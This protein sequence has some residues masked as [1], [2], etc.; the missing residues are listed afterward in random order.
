MRY[1]WDFRRMRRYHFW[2]GRRWITTKDIAWII[3]RDANSPQSL[4]SPTS[5][6]SIIFDN[7]PML[8]SSN[9]RTIIW[10]GL[11]QC[12]K[13]TKTSYFVVQGNESN[14]S[15]VSTFL[16]GIIWRKQILL[17][18]ATRILKCVVWYDLKCDLRFGQLGFPI[19]V[20]DKYFSST[21]R[22]LHPVKRYILPNFRL[23][24]SPRRYVSLVA[25]RLAVPR[26]R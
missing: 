13:S 26:S 14:V 9:L 12:F 1:I 4:T 18:A 17:K 8:S 3:K 7:G 23:K 20:L 15:S 2:F 11:H 25:S 19:I 24:F 6:R 22:I 10:H 5:P 16:Y 21:R